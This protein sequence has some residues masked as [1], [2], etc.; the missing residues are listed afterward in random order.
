MASVDESIE[1]TLL[2]RL[3]VPDD[4]SMAPDVARAILSLRFSESDQSRMRELL[5]RASDGVLIQGEE[6][7]ASSYQRIGS[8]LGMMQ[9]KARLSL[10]RAKLAS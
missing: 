3:I 1:L 5:S 7:E 4:P 8:F 9:S 10:K 6:A 2:E